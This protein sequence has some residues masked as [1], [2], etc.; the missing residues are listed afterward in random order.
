M[1]TVTKALTLLDHFTLARPL[2]GLSEV[3]RL[4]G[5]NKATAFRLL[6]ELQSA[7]FVEQAGSAREYLPHW[8]SL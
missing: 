7:G 6:S 2:I 4:A 5:V 3:A 1:G 8:L